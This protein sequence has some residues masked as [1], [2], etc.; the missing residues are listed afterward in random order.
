MWIFETVKWSILPTHDRFKTDHEKRHNNS[1]K[2][3]PRVQERKFK[4][5]KPDT[6]NRTQLKSQ[7]TEQESSSQSAQTK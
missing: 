6:I 2:K 7:N 3:A 1:G 4:V 5:A